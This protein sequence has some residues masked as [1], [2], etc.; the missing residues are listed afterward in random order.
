MTGGI[1]YKKRKTTE[2]VDRAEEEDLCD[3][4]IRSGD[5][6]HWRRGGGVG[7][8]GIPWTAELVAKVRYFF[9]L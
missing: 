9:F 3:M 5:R 6:L 2:D 8:Q 1:Q 7:C 4:Q